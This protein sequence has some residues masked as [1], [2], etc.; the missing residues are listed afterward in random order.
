LEKVGVC[1]IGCGGISRSHFRAYAQIKEASLVAVVDIDENRA[2]AA[3]EEFGAHHHFTDYTRALESDEVDMVDICLPTHLHA[4][5]AVAAAQSGKHILTEKPI[6]LTLEDADR[7]S[8][9]ASE[10]GVKFTVGFGLRF[11]TR[12]MKFAQLVREGA[13]GRPVVFRV[14]NSRRAPSN[15][16]YTDA[17][18]GGGPV[19]DKAVHTYDICRYLFGSSEALAEPTS[20]YATTARFQETHSAIDTASA[21][22][23]FDSGDSLAMLLSWGLPPDAKATSIQ[24]AIGPQGHLAFGAPPEVTKDVDTRKYS[25]ITL[26]GGKEPT[27]H[28]FESNS[29]MKDQLHSFIKAIIEDTE[30]VVTAYDGRRA[31][32]M[33]LAILESGRTGRVFKFTHK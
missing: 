10:A 8:R 23:N 30:P 2:L 25:F 31:L 19:I 13:L 17:K 32:E 33:G 11:S 3:Q 27:Y 4:E 22:V 14:V 7:M 1:L 9:A 18:K 24:D 28:K 20:V 21:V 29:H 16:W 6:A 26:T 5:A 12:M 15:P